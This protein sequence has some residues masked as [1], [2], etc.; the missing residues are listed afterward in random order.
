ME[1]RHLR[2]FVTVAEEL[3][4]SKAALKL[5]TAQPSLSQ[6][7][8]D[9]E[10]YVGVQ[11]FNRTKRK[12][13]LTEEG[14]A[15]L[16]QARLTL[17][18]A[19]KAVATARQIAKTKQQRL[20]I[21]FVAT[22]EV[23]IFPQVL[24][25]LRIQHPELITEF[26]YLDEQQ[27][28]QAL[29]QN[30]LDIA[31]THQNLNTETICSQKIFDEVLIFVLPKNH[32]FAKEKVIPLHALGYLDFVLPSAEQFPSLYALICKFIQQHDFTLHTQEMTDVLI[33]INQLKHQNWCTILPAYAK[34]MFSSDLVIATLAID[35]PKLPL[36]INFNSQQTSNH[37]KILLEQL[38][39]VFC[40]E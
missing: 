5:Y 6:Q 3:N 24:P 9:L 11:L 25:Q 36:F 23:H 16:E 32:P 28:I 30:Q 1:L 39:K 35:L 7:I 13:E 38:S 2:Y 10:E 22:A 20:R 27:N 15:F 40:S 29:M 19:D 34:N 4:F 12:V 8:K 17:M 37:T 21:G 14:A 33:K 31:F 18:Q 26:T